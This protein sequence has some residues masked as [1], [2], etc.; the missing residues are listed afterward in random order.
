MPKKLQTC[1]SNS[2]KE[3]VLGIQLF[4][5]SSGMGARVYKRLL[6]AI[7]HFPVL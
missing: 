3:L 7:Q 6:R 1:C 4:L 2:S 5:I